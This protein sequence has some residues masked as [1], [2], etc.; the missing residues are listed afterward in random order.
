MDSATVSS[1]TDSANVHDLVFPQEGQL[2][3]PEAEPLE[4]VEQAA[5]AGDDAVAAPVGQVA[6]KDLED[7]T[8]RGR[9]TAQRGLEHGEFVVVSQQRGCPAVRHSG[10]RWKTTDKEV[11]ASERGTR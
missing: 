4:C 6:G 3:R 9:T 11:R 2:V 8:P 10:H 1:R 5:S 7:R